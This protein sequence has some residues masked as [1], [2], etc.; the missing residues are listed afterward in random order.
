MDAGLTRRT[1]A[2]MFVAPKDHSTPKHHSAQNERKN[3]QTLQSAAQGGKRLNGGKHENLLV[4]KENLVQ[5]EYSGSHSPVQIYQDTSVPPECPVITCC[6]NTQTDDSL[7]D[8]L[9]QERWQSLD[10]VQGDSGRGSTLGEQET[11]GL[12]VDDTPSGTYWKELA[13]ERR[14][15]LKET[16]KENEKLCTEIDNLKEENSRLADIAKKAE[17]LQELLSDIVEDEEHTGGSCQEPEGDSQFVDSLKD[18]DAEKLYADLDQAA[19]TSKDPQSDSKTQDPGIY[20]SAGTA[21]ESGSSTN[22]QVSEA[23]FKSEKTA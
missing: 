4:S 21:Q 8:C 23:Q 20:S 12:L 14:I 16:L 11:L 7:L 2:T 3:L 9:L 22:S 13:E 18:E 5:P 1:K 17:A 19:S 6:R 10:S 15:A